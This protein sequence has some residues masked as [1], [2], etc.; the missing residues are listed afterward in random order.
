ML[1]ITRLGLIAGAL[2]AALAVGAC[3]GGDTGRAGGKPAGKTTVLKLANANGQ[4]DELQLF[5]DQ[6][7]KL[8]DGRLRIEAANGWRRGETDYETGLL[9]DVKAGKADLGWVGSR[10]LA[11]VAVKSF[12][13]LH[14]PFLIDSYELQDLVVGGD[15]AKRM[16]TDLEDVGLTGVA[17]LP[18]PLRYL[19]LDRTVDG[20]DG[21]AGLKIGYIDSPLQEAALTALGSEPVEIS[22]GGSIRGL[23]GVEM[24]A[25]ATHGNHY[26]D[27]AP[28]TVADAPLW[29]RPFVVFAD[30]EAWKA[31][32][33][34][35]RELVT[36]A[37]E[38]ARAGMLVALVERE[39]RSV[40]G[41]CEAGNRMVEVGYAGRA[42][43][44]AAV[45][46]LIAKLRNDPA[47]RDAMAEIESLRAG[48]SP[49][50]VRCPAGTSTQK[51]A[52]TG[53]F[54]TTIRKSEAGSDAIPEDWTDS[55]AKAIRFK[56]ELS[57]GRA[58]ITEYYPS[59][60]IT[61]FDEDYTVFKDV[62]E[63]QAGGGGPP[64][65]ARWDL[66]G[67]RLRFT[68]VGGRPDDK[69]VWTR[70]WTKTG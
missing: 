67:K 43:M 48:G 39:Q 44:Q 61:G 58:V 34:A 30:T 56:L 10:A 5:I 3:G 26:V 25:L 24:H 6:V 15:V 50:G 42:Q 49:H 64:L 53:V 40:E 69:F 62:I 23:N 68:D 14:A 55:G 27:T 41:M 2:T 20:P 57:D 12:E 36:K 13:P 31:L 9:Q 46:P 11:N 29:P 33:E 4:A 19:Q 66:D 22:S 28:N 1:R 54:E 32:P 52:L 18:G 65:T 17:V 38:Q 21:L 37:A 35:D 47:T 70:T 51:A 59:G 7:D 8:S 63:F 16:L 45:G 60:P